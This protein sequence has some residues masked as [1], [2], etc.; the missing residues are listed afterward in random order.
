MS[1][2]KVSALPAHNKKNSR[3]SADPWPLWGAALVVGAGVF[4]LGVVS[5]ER[6]VEAAVLDMEV[7]AHAAP[8]AALPAVV[9]PRPAPAP[10]PAPTEQ[11]QL[12]AAKAA[13]EASPQVGCSLLRALYL[14]AE[15]ED[16]VRA[17][18]DLL[19][20][21]G[22]DDWGSGAQG[23]F[24]RA[25]AP[26]AL[27][28]SRETGIP[29]SV[30]LAQA[31]LESGWGKS[32][33]ARENNNLFGMK[34]RGPD[35]SGGYRQYTSWEQS[36]LHHNALLAESARY[37]AARAHLGDWRAF[38]RAMAPVYATSRT[39]V[40]QV[41]GLVERYGLDRWDSLVLQ[42]AAVGDGLADANDH[43]ER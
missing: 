18:A 40:G 43:D 39:Y 35:S 7:P 5:A 10:A 27:M 20:E 21:V 42:A 29:P 23:A 14:G 30:T 12:A 4:L 26:A 3:A 31:I 33:L 22:A 34:G 32:G 9:A 37:A 17:A 6:R 36:L 11:E 15:E 1:V 41:S 8:E 38:L 19:V 13:L 28:A 24:L 25:L 16:V 2:G